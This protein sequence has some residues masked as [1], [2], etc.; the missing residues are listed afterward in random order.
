M[1]I[2][3]DSAATWAA[4]HHIRRRILFENRGQLGVYD[5]NR[6]DEQAPGH[7]P[8]LLV[9][10]S[11]HVGVVRIDVAGTTA[12]LR[13]VAIDEPYQR[14]GLGRILLALAEAF[15]QT[16]GARR[17]ESAVA[18]DAVPFYDK[19]GYRP[20]AERD[21]RRSEVPMWKDLESTVAAP[22]A[23]SRTPS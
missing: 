8:K 21:A 15:A 16:H 7:F 1:L 4:Y 13:R 3:P 14:R 2:S 5:E 12:Y 10:K 20:S 17:I 9:H 11:K 22:A 19:C 6:P 23:R 18:V